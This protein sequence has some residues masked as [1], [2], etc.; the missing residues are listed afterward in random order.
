MTGTAHFTGEAS[1]IAGAVLL[2]GSP[3]QAFDLL[4]LAPQDDGT[5]V[6]A[7][8]ASGR[9]ATRKS[10]IDAFDCRHEMGQ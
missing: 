5:N 10:W 4:G 6:S 1:W 7:A 9:R 3:E 2:R 8:G